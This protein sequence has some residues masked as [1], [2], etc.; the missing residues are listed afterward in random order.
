MEFIDPHNIVQWFASIGLVENPEKYASPVQLHNELRNGI[1]L[2]RLC[3]YI[4]PGTVPNINEHASKE[5]KAAIENIA[6][7]VTATKAILGRD[8]FGSDL[9]PEG[10]YNHGEGL[11]K[12]LAVLF[13]LK[14]SLN[15]RSNDVASKTAA[16]ASVQSQSANTAASKRT[17]P[18]GV[19]GLDYLSTGRKVRK[20]CQSHEVFRAPLLHCSKGF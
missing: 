5:K 9:S 1:V 19:E 17:T 7:Y 20:I 14:Q 6:A 10:F 15:D 18:P 3:N 12:L 2:C 16:S 11:H 4:Q 13:L 8:V